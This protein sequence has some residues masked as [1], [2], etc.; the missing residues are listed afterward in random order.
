M[1]E[2]R[3]KVGVGVTIFKDGKVLLGKRKVKN[4]A[5]NEYAG[6]G[7]HLEFGE[8]FEECA[9]RETREECGIEIKNVQFAIL[10]NLLIYEGK[11]Y[12]DI[13][14]MAEW[15]SGEP[16]VLEPE[17]SESWEWYALDNLPQPL[18]A[19]DKMRLEALKTG[20]IYFGTIRKE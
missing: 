10:S 20:Q 6:P 19:G 7:G 16:K 4:H 15:A 14:M 3:I 11:H 1:D 2:P 9:I 18:I 5:E 8:S 12:V 17:K 13:G